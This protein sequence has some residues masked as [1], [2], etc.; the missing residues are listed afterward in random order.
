MAPGEE[1]EMTSVRNVMLQP[2]HGSGIV[3]LKKALGDQTRRRTTSA[4]LRM[5]WMMMDGP[6]FVVRPSYPKCGI[7]I[8]SVQS[9]T[10]VAVEFIY[11]LT[12]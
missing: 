1:V 8:L 6:Q 11:K 7:S 9:F 5:R 3:M 4:V 12:E 10:A 2:D